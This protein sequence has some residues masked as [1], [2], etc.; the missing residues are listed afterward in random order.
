M[1]LV[2]GMVEG[3]VFIQEPRN[4]PEVMQVL[5]K[6][7]RLRTDQDAETSYNSLRLVASLDVAPD[8]AAWKNIQRF[9]SRVSPKV[10]QLDIHQIINGSFVKNLEETGFLPEARKKQGL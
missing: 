8:P 2:K 4:K 5:K 1:R 9:V 3:V 7:L 6:N 10:A